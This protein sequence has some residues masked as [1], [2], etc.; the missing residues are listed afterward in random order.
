IIFDSFGVLVAH[1]DFARLAQEARMHP[2]HLRLPEIWEIRTGPVGTVMRSWDGSDRF[3]GSIRGEDGRDYLF[4]LQKFSQGDEYS[5]FSLLFAA[6]DDF[7]QNVRK[8]QIRGIVVALIIG[9][10]FVPAAWFFG[11]RMST[12]LKRMTAQARSLQTLAAPQDAPVA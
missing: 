10:C 3:E 11:S 1:P 6:E 9:G 8:L 4:R 2:A 12:S 7:A 5:G